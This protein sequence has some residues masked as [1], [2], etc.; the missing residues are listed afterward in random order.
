MNSVQFA[1]PETGEQVELA[2]GDTFECYAHHANQLASFDFLKA[3]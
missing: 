3:V 1:D 2:P